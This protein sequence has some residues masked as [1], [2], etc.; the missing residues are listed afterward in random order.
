MQTRGRRGTAS[1]VVPDP[2]PKSHGRHATESQLVFSNREKRM[3]AESRGSSVP[4]I[5]DRMSRIP[6]DDF[7]PPPVPCSARPN[8]TVDD[9]YSKVDDEL[10]ALPRPISSADK[11]GGEEDEWALAKPR[12]V[13]ESSSDSDD[14]D[15]MGDDRRRVKKKSKDSMGGG[16][17]YQ[18]L[19]DIPTSTT[20][21]HR[22]V[23]KNDY[24]DIDVAMPIVSKSVKARPPA[25]D[26]R[27]RRAKLGSS[28]R[29]SG[30]SV[31]SANSNSSLVSPPPSSRN[32]H[33]S[34]SSTNEDLSLGE[35]PPPPSSAR[36]MNMGRKSGGFSASCEYLNST[37]DYL[38]PADSSPFPGPTPPPPVDEI[39]KKNV[40][41]PG[42]PAPPVPQSSRPDIHLSVES[43]LDNP[44]HSWSPSQDARVHSAAPPPPPH[45]H[46]LNPQRP[47][48]S[49]NLVAP[50]QRPRSKT[51]SEVAP[52]ASARPV[53][54]R[55]GKSNVCV[56][57]ESPYLLPEDE[58][59]KMRASVQ[60]PP[61]LPGESF[62]SDAGNLPCF[63]SSS[64]PVRFGDSFMDGDMFDDGFEEDG[65]QL[66]YRSD[67]PCPHDVSALSIPE[68]KEFQTDD[69]YLA[70]LD[71]LSHAGETPP[72]PD[73]NYS[74]RDLDKSLDADIHRY[75]LLLQVSVVDILVL[76]M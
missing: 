72:L 28:R 22:P 2:K 17:G 19:D 55:V 47:D 37:D 57:A 4:V 45:K 48:S 15:T 34:L 54:P 26:Q 64:V 12:L 20:P 56:V 40:H 59:K 53:F 51:S 16:D 52:P 38:D 35:A 65:A 68:D 29:H 6:V 76:V 7:P 58:I 36:P 25:Q 23:A 14:M 1:E 43:S 13:L 21:A 70:P 61:A 39:F 50:S 62:D 41:R 11:T 9:G 71:N 30:A 3:S 49:S 66:P 8:M 27:S 32:S 31:A 46:I 73:R 60:P 33:V 5:S 69:I 67:Q 75:N 18:D 44:R 42:Q 24:D 74:R 63:A 10:L